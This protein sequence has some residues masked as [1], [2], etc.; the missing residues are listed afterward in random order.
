MGSTPI[1]IPIYNGD[2]EQFSEYYKFRDGKE[3]LS[4]FNEENLVKLSQATGWQYTHLDPRHMPNTD[5]FMQQ[6][7]DA[8]QEVGRW[9]IFDYPVEVA[10]TLI[11][12]V[13][14]G[15]TFAWSVSK[16]RGGRRNHRRWQ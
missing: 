1:Q 14:L 8:K 7:T 10:L 13:G 11:L 15:D 3:A 9:Y 4:G 5:F 2:D 12:L 16:M 6:L